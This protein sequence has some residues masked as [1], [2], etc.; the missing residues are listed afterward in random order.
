M[1]FILFYILFFCVEKLVLGA[2]E[3]KAVDHGSSRF[4]DLSNNEDGPS[5][6]KGKEMLNK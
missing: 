5:E 4:V 6:Q 2:E 1:L 3:V